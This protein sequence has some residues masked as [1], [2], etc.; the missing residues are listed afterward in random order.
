MNGGGRVADALLS[1]Q[2]PENPTVPELVGIL[3]FAPSGASIITEALAALGN[4]AASFE[5]WNMAL[6]H[7]HVGHIPEEATDICT[8][9]AIGA[10]ESVIQLESLSAHANQDQLALIITK[11]KVIIASA[12]F[13]DCKAWLHESHAPISIELLLQMEKSAEFDEQRLE[14]CRTITL[15]KN[16]SLIALKK[17]LLTTLR[18][19]GSI[20]FDKWWEVYTETSKDL[21]GELKDLA[22]TKAQESRPQA[23]SAA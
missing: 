12:S 19:S 7:A 1:N 14:L 10:A 11:L 4:S 3:R 20:S 13:E 6:Y 23:A 5:I 22:W 15:P 8:K 9:K 2:L 16:S 21:N 17:R 18:D